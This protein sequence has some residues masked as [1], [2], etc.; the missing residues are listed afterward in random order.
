MSEGDL[1]RDLERLRRAYRGKLTGKLAQ[2]DFLLGE[3]RK[4]PEREEL[5]AARD[6]AHTL[7]G[8]S[9]S[10]GFDES[11]AEFWRIEERLDHLLEGASEGAAAAWKE[12]EQA[13]KR[14][15]I[16]CS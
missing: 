9:G 6:L 15:R 5:E 4:V 11:S 7:Q 8:T 16:A 3:A 2:L 14:A 13:L 10:Y 1:E 12:I